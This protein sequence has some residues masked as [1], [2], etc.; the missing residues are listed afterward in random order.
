MIYSPEINRTLT[1]FDN[2]ITLH[3]YIIL[4]LRKSGSLCSCWSFFFTPDL[5]VS[6]RPL[7]VVS[8]LVE[9][10]LH[11]F[12]A[13]WGAWP[14][15][16][17]LPQV[18]PISLRS[19]STPRSHV[20]HN[21]ILFNRWACLLRQ[22]LLITVYLLLTKET[23]F[24]I[25]FP[26]ASNKWKF[27]VSILHLQQTNGSCRFLFIP[28]SVKIYKYMYREMASWHHMY[29]N[30]LSISSLCKWKFVVCLFVDKET[31]QSYPF[32]NGLNRLNRLVHLW[33]YQSWALE[34]MKQQSN[35]AMQWSIKCF[36]TLISLPALNAS[37]LRHCFNFLSWLMFYHFIASR[38]YLNCLNA[39]T[40]KYINAQKRWF[41]LAIFKK[42]AYF[43]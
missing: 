21:N 3:N 41:A 19:Q 14:S 24:C 6:P 11:I 30:P 43:T 28:F 18:D 20:R 34:M 27:A 2:S 26:F 38:I 4:V 31:N 15:L 22:Q 40:N 5:P 10:W 9:H 7:P 13:S 32:A 33:I 39:L 17:P 12:P 35:E 37:S 23:N 8:A 25:L 42:F 36:I 29:N 16:T 1:Q